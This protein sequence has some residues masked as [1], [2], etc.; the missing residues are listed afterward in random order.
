MQ[1]QK[2][3]KD[4][5]TVNTKS[6]PNKRQKMIVDP[7]GQWAHPGENTRIPGGD[8]TMQGV[9][10]PVYARANNGMEQL[11]HP[12]Q[13]YS[14]PGADYVDEYP[15]MQVGG[16][17]VDLNLPMIKSRGANRINPYVYYQKPDPYTRVFGVG[18][19]GNVQ[20]NNR[21][22]FTGGANF[23]NINVPIAGINQWTPSYNAG[24]TYK[25][26]F[27]G[28]NQILPRYQERPGT[29]NPFGIQPVL[30]D[31]QKRKMGMPVAQRSVMYN[32]PPVVYPTAS[33]E[34]TEGFT[35]R[36]NGTV[37]A[38]TQKETQDWQSERD[39][40]KFRNKWFGSFAGAKEG[41]KRQR[42]HEEN[43]ETDENVAA[44]NSA[45]LARDKN[46]PFTFPTGESKTWDKMSW[47]EK[48]YVEGLARNR[49][50]E[51]FPS[52]TSKE[53]IK[54]AIND[55]NPFPI[56]TDW[57]KGFSQS[58][59]LAEKTDS[60]MPYVAAAAD[61]ALTI[62]AIALASP[63]LRATDILTKDILNPAKP[64][65]K[66]AKFMTAVEEGNMATFAEKKLKKDLIKDTGKEINKSLK[67]DLVS[68][69]SESQLLQL[70]NTASNEGINSVGILNNPELLRGITT[71][72]RP[73]SFREGGE[74]NSLNKN[75]TDMN[76]L[77]SL[78]KYADGSIV[79]YLADRNQDYSKEA[80]AKLAAKKGIKDYDFSAEKNLELLHLLQKE[81]SRSS[82]QTKQKEPARPVSNKPA[83]TGTP[84]VTAANPVRPSV[85]P[86]YPGMLPT[87][88]GSSKPPTP[89]DKRN[90]ESGVIVDKG[91][92]EMYFVD[93]GKIVR[94]DRVGTGEMGRYK[95]KDPNKNIGTGAQFDPTKRSTPTG[96]YFMEP[97]ADIYGWPGFQMNPISAYGQPA[98]QAEGLA[99]HIIY[100]APPKPGSGLKSHSDPKEF[101]R[102]NQMFAAP[103][104][105]RYMSWGCTNMKGETVDCA[106]QMF[107]RGD[108]AV[109]ID[110]RNPADLQYIKQMQSQKN[111]GSTYS[112]GVWYMN[113]GDIPNYMQDPN[114]MYNFGGYFPQAP[115][116]SHGGQTMDNTMMGMINVF[117]QGGIVEGQIMDVTPDMLEKLKA[118]GYTFEMI[119]D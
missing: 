37:R 90:L 36:Q 115:R 80:R 5:S 40:E 48:A 16:I 38:L 66:I 86:N 46:E 42:M 49:T 4:G 109:Y 102:R 25:L 71:G 34:R 92:N 6:L 22:G 68:S 83:W 72:L 81:E 20:L 45:I 41:E 108:T 105:N 111:G 19:E 2:K 75:F 1:D 110:S 112:A 30:T 57:Y 8:I 65:Q 27:G 35:G 18:A 119:N 39:A 63:E 54:T 60:Y 24:I 21:F 73:T 43:R 103:G 12:G 13:E 76:Y 26:A 87:Y 62:G 84:Y 69:P 99:A 14:F 52:A 58:P 118:G 53:P 82:R 7:M 3:V 11:M 100:G 96:T 17:P 106:T 32:K 98:P 114:P 56:L 95:D 79:D 70:E 31:E 28:M 44:T 116:F 15:M 55:L 78:T 61:P 91:T 101:A 89:K 77:Q 47:R 9:P 85:M 51:A 104:N 29:V 74:Y 23:Q 113:G 93:K 117:E 97:D 64:I 107:P 67:S 33:K 50:F 10:Y 94:T 88:K 59:Y